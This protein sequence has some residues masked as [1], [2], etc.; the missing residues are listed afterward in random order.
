MKFKFTKLAI[1]DVIL[2]EPE[3]AG[4]ARGFFSEVFRANVFAEAAVAGPFVQENH[5]RSAKGVLRGLHF[6]RPPKPLGKL[7][8]CIRGEIFDVAVDVRKGSPTFGKFVAERLSEEN[9]RMLYVPE[10]FA[11]GF[12]VLSDTA[13]AVY[14]QT[15]YWAPECE[16]GLAWNDPD[17][18]IPWPLAQPTIHPRDAAWP[19]LKALEAV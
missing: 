10:G 11:H 17:V 3:A 7:I 19:A 14:K 1:P 12:Q 6:Q 15:G 18:A 16:G 8:R 2:I 4:D 5:S 9:R 13:D